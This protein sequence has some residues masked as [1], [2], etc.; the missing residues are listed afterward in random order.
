MH[1][2]QRLRILVHQSANSAR[3]RSGE[4]VGDHAA[5]S[6]ND[7]ILTVHLFG[8]RLPLHRLKMGFAVRMIELIA[9]I[10]PG[11]AW[12]IG[13]GTGPANAVLAVN[14]VPGNAVVIADA[15]LGRDAQLIKYFL[16]GVER[17]FAAL[18]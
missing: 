17:K 9:F 5:S 18:T 12:M 2:T 11:C 13:G 3:L 10:K 8:C 14:A 16:G 1:L 4:V 7:G 15:A 6:K